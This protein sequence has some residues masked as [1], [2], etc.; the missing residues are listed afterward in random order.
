MIPIDTLIE[1][2]GIATEPWGVHGQA[3][4]VQPT[5]QSVE[6]IR[7]ELGVAIPND[8]IRIATACTSYVG[9]LA[10]IGEDYDHHC[11]ILRL[12]ETFHSPEEPPALPQH[13]VLLNHGHDGDCDCWDVRASTVSGEHP[14]VYV[15]MESDTPDASGLRFESFRAYI[16]HFVRYQAPRAASSS[17]RRRAQTLLEECGV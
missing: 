15:D 10:S 16:E 13:F 7:R 2:V 17:R 4:P 3:R 6:R 9:W 1:L 14:I 11:H 5:A 8:Y 12:N